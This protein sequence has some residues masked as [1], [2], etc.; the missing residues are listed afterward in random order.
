MKRCP[1]CCRI[2]DHRAAVCQVDGTTLD[3]LNADPLVGQT[4]SKRYRVVRKLGGGSL[5][6]VYLAEE[7]ATG[8][9]VA[10]KFLLKELHWDAELVKQC[11]WDARFA[12]ASNPSSIVRVYEVDRTDEGRVFIVMECLE[13]ESLAELLRLE[14]VLELG[15]ALRLASQIA[16]SLA[17]AFKAGVTHRNLKPH[18]IMI[19]GPDH[20]IK[21]TGFGVARFRET[22]SGV[23]QAGLIAPEYTAPEQLKGDNV[24]DRA[25]IYTLGAVLYAMLT[26]SA[27]STAARQG[28]EEAGDLRAA[29][30]PLRRMRPEIPAALE[31][32]VMRAIE[33]RPEDRQNGMEQCLET[34]RNLT[35]S[36]VAGTATDVRSVIAWSHSLLSP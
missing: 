26:G 9:N 8:N 16:N 24:A 34:L 28:A 19:V 5:G 30:A 13:G 6:P 15:P 11:W 35:K 32:F 36:V 31:Q 25:D 27:P 4:I 1:D 18:D 22:A 10:V 12:T 7:L 29:P 2:Y 14:G 23:A 17:A 3:D 33:P 20:R 21:L